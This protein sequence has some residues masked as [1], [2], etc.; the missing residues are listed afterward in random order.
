M[1]FT[2]I[3]LSNKVLSARAKK[4]DFEILFHFLSSAHAERV[5]S[6]MDASQIA[7]EGNVSVILTKLKVLDEGTYIC[8][9]SIGLFHAQQVIQLQVIR[10]FHPGVSVQKNP[11]KVPLFIFCLFCLFQNHLTCPFQRRNWF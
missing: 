1:Y 3:S 10:K 4:D 9:V 5:G 7:G 11:L 8:T 2:Q 6:S